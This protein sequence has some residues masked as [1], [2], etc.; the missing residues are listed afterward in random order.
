MADRFCI[1]S[2]NFTDPSIWSATDG[3]NGG[4]SVP[5]DTDDRIFNSSVA[6]TDYPQ[7]PGRHSIAIG[8]MAD[9][10]ISQTPS[11]SFIIGHG[12]TIEGKLTVV[13]PTYY[14]SVRANAVIDLKESGIWD[15]GVRSLRMSTYDLNTNTDGDTHGV[16]DNKGSIVAGSIDIHAANN[17]TAAQRIGKASKLNIQTRAAVN[18]VSVVGVRFRCDMDVDAIR[19]LFSESLVSTLVCNWGNTRIKTKDLEWDWNGASTTKIC[20]VI[21]NGPMEVSGDIRRIGGSPLIV[22]WQLGAGARLAFVGTADQ[23]IDIPPDIT[24]QVWTVDKP[25][26]K[27]DLTTFS[28]FL[29]GRLRQ[30]IVRAASS[31]D[32]AGPPPILQT[33]TGMP[34]G[35]HGLKADSASPQGPVTVTEHLQE[36]MDSCE[37]YGLLTIP[38]GKTL[39]TK[40]FQNYTGAKISGTGTLCVRYGGLSNAGTIDP[41]VNVHYF[42]KPVLAVLSAPATVFAN[43]IFSVDLTGSVGIWFRIDWDDDSFSETQTPGILKHGYIESEGI[44]HRTLK[45]TVGNDEGKTDS[46]TKTLTV[47]P[48]PWEPGIPTGPGSGKQDP[49]KT[50]HGIPRGNWPSP[51]RFTLA[52]GK[53]FM[54]DTLQ[55]FCPMNQSGR[56]LANGSGLYLGRITHSD[57]RLPDPEEIASAHYTVYRLDAS[58]ATVRTPIEGHTEIPLDVTEILLEE[59]VVDENWPFDAIGYNFRHTPN[60]TTFP[61]FPVA[62]RAYLIV[63]TLAPLDI[64]PKIVFQYR[65]HVL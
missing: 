38:G 6:V 39:C 8:P 13:I 49:K 4:A 52:L 31:V 63:Y 36:A 30:L 22:D 17:P 40:S 12:L 35:Y 10:T 41:T 54:H 64:S 14:A 32:L 37:N 28:G 47:V 53:R 61:L 42:D 9:V 33:T 19:F 44:V 51:Y 23:T 43:S 56:A 55:L 15:L 48:S 5:A 34:N 16:I 57:G 65:V 59:A 20:Q 7:T 1:A 2:G 46:V 18:N 3:G 11:D 29:Q 58:D 45:L 26:G 24:G 25:A 60:D 21:Q 50:L 27:L 62:G